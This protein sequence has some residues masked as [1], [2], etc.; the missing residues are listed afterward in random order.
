MATHRATIDW[1]LD[2]DFLGRRYSRAHTLSFDGGVVV[3]AS[4]SPHVVRLPF[5]R[6]DAVDPEEGFTASLSSCHLLW[7][8]DF[9]SRAGFVVA[10]YRDEAEGTLDKD[11]EGRMAMTR[12]VLRPRVEWVGDKRPTPAEVDALHHQAHEACFIANSVKTEVL[13]EAVPG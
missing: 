9:A 1:T 12:V 13:I 7:F 3:P 10:G 2:G 5:S 6:E 8:L 11:A 4:S